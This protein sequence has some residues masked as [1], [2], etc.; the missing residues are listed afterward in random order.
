LHSNHSFSFGHYYNPEQM[1][2]GPLLVINE[3]RV[4]AGK[5]FGTHAHENMEIISYVLSGALEHKDSLGT[6]SIIRYGDVQRMS[7]GTG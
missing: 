4:Q 3:D 2:F 5:G 7:A 6:G 1:G